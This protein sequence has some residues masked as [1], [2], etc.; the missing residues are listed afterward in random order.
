MYI[1]SVPNRSSPPAV[2]LRES[3]RAGG[4]VKKRT[5][6]NLSKLPTAAI[7]TL[8]RVL[9]GERLVNPE[10][11]FTCVR[12]LPH[13]HIAAVL[14]TLK[15]IGLHTLI[16]RNAGRLRDL[17]LALIVARVIDAQS[18]LATARGLA[19]ESAVST[20]GETLGL[21]DVD[22]HELY[23]AMD[24][25]VERQ[26]A[27]EQRLAKQHLQEHTLVLYDLTSSYLE[28]THCP[29]AQ[30]GHSRDGKQGTLQIV[31]GLLCT[32]AGCPVAV[33]GGL[34][35][36]Q[37]PHP[38]WLAAGG[39]GG[40]PRHADRSADPRGPGGRR[41]AA[42][43]HHAAGADDSET[44]GR[45]HGDAVAVRQAGPGRGHQR[46]VPRRAAGRVPQSVAGR[47]AAA[48][49]AGTAGG[50][51]EGPGAHRGSDNAPEPAA[52][53]SSRNRYARREG[54][55]PAQDGQAFR[56]HDHRRHVHL[57][58]GRRQDRGRGAARGC[59][60]S[61]PTSSRSSSMQRRR[62]GL[63]GPVE[64][65]VRS[66]SV[67]RGRSRRA[68]RVRA[69]VL[70]CMLAYYVEWH[71]RHALAPLLFDDHDPAAAEQQRPSVVAAAR[72]SPAALAKVGC[73]RTDDD[74]PVHS[75]RLLTDLGTLTAN[76][77]QVAESGVTFQLQTDPTPLQQR[78]FELLGVTTRV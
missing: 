78:C 68:D 35:G 53:R 22:Q 75:F 3:Y 14:G 26:A 10:D 52:T 4:H 1:E 49:A 48:Q 18:K 74:L 51:R 23:A 61:A 60:S 67:D 20:L 19:P 57:S 65:H 45:R 50:N 46:A 40:R 44:A 28:G 6:A 54:D 37:A 73:K 47:R 56:H 5:L 72:R 29:L 76:T 27:I 39:A 55:Q 17:V 16:A 36:G 21:G 31:F 8:R 13:G 42:L 63:Q 2:L 58:P 62:W 59:T 7:E 11:A 38:L 15:R 12:S 34:P 32:A 66:K 24:W 43:D 9:R 77:M 30:R 69:H 70:L 41:R 64:R 33:E 25:L 71:M